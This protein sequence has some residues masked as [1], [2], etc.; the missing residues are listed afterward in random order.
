MSKEYGEEILVLNG[1]DTLHTFKEEMKGRYGSLKL[2]SEEKVEHCNYV[3]FKYV[4]R[5]LMH[6]YRLQGN[7]PDM[8]YL[9]RIYEILSD[10]EL[11]Y[12]VNKSI[13]DIDGLN[14]YNEYNYDIDGAVY[15][16]S[17]RGGPN[18]K[19]T[20]PPVIESASESSDEEFVVLNK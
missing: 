19:S 11:K 10:G 4:S 14:P 2:K 9:Y 20:P 7:P 8:G 18:R 1:P 12:L 15:V 5:S 13:Y 16:N 17:T 6:I 3:N